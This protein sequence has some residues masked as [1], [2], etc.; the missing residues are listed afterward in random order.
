MIKQNDILRIIARR[1]AGLEARQAE[2]TLLKL[3]FKQSESAEV[4]ALN[5]QAR[6]NRVSLDIQVLFKSI[7]GVLHDSKRILND[8]STIDHLINSYNLF[9]L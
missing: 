8:T 4:I 5:R 3:G 9:I 2:T 7:E 6:S 1:I